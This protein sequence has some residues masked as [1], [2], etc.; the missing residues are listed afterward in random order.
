MA[1]AT[2]SFYC[3]TRIPN[4]AAATSPPMATRTCA[5]T[6][7]S[8]YT[9]TPSPL[10]FA[11]KKRC[12]KPSTLVVSAASTAVE[13]DSQLN[14][15]VPSKSLPFRVGHGFDLHRLEPGYPLIIGGIN[16]PHERG[17]EAHSDGKIVFPFI[18]SSIILTF[19]VQNYFLGNFFLIIN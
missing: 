5:T 10:K 15:A 17:C 13:A 4:K 16:I 18:F 12:S 8:Y 2:T 19:L 9:T 6:T 3:A 14:A 11:S 1:M 7:L